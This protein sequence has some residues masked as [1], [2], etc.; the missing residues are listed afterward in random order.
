MACCAIFA[1]TSYGLNL[2]S[3]D[4]VKSRFF[5]AI[6]QQ[7]QMQI[8]K[9]LSQGQVHIDDVD[10]YGRT[11]L[12]IAATGSDLHFIHFLLNRGADINYQNK[13]GLT[14]LNGAA[15][16]G[17]LEIFRYLVARGSDPQ[18]KDQLGGT[19]L[20]FAQHNGHQ[21][22]VDFILEQH[23]EI[24]TNFS[25]WDALYSAAY[26]GDL[27]IF[28]YLVEKV[29]TT[30]AEVNIG[31][32]YFADALS[33]KQKKQPY[34]A[35]IIKANI[36]STNV[37]NTPPHAAQMFFISAGDQITSEAY[38]IDLGLVNPTSQV[39]NLAPYEESPKLPNISENSVKTMANNDQALM[40]GAQLWN[41][42]VVEYIRYNS[43]P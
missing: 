3:D 32:S 41:Q 2:S 19:V 37:N 43:A 25:D 11:A 36:T 13:L 21:Q 20:T 24:S 40:L 26:S 6:L 28:Q 8:D 29:K 5:Q 12:Y 34:A 18:V 22:I 27:D 14:A 9:L 35:N 33:D 10:E 1:A 7:D 31:L 4:V 42:Y 30:S 16:G 38:S 17:N 23:G 39:N 15:L